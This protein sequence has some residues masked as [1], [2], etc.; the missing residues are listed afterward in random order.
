MT[1]AQRLL[2]VT[3]HPS[4]ES[5][6]AEITRRFIAGIGAQ[7][8][9]RERD[10]YRVGFNPVLS[11][12]EWRSGFSGA[13]PEDC[14]VEQEHIQWATCLAWIFPAWNFGLPAILKGYL[15]RVFLIPGF[16]FASDATGTTYQGGLLRHHRALVIQTLGSN[17]QTAYRFGNV[18]S[19]AAEAVSSLQYAGIRNVQ[20]AQ[21]W[22]MYRQMPAVPAEIE[23]ILSHA[24]GLGAS[25]FA[26]TVS[27]VQIVS[28]QV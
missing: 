22:N 11:E 19:Y 16:S 24:Q 9:V 23:K 4:K 18:A 3:A 5:L 27:G 28:S 13:V 8:E 26:D 17:L 12:E 7:A 2:I 15:D 1:S 21:Y 14:K 20:V 25:F 6:N 10:L